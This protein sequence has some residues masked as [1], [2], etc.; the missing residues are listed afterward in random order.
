MVA[1]RA[2]GSKALAAP[3]RPGAALWVPEHS[4]RDPTVALV[5]VLFPYSQLSVMILKSLTPALFLVGAQWGVT[6]GAGVN[7][8]WSTEPPARLHLPALGSTRARSQSRFPRT[9]EVTG[10]GGSFLGC[11]HT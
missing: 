6:R 9:K 7:F 4:Q 5:P 10:S 11:A 8:P 3:S 1:A 2:Q